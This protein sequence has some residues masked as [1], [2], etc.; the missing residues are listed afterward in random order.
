MISNNTIS[1]KPVVHVSKDRKK[2]PKKIP[3]YECLNREGRGRGKSKFFDNPST[4]YW[5][6]KVCHSK[7]KSEFDIKIKE[8]LELIELVKISELNQ[9]GLLS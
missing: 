9:R 1:F 4:L 5:H 3:C 7:R 6:K 8:D 2:L